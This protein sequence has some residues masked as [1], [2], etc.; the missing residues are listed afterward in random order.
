M[1]SEKKYIKMCSLYRLNCSRT[2]V[3]VWVVSFGREM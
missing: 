3:I 2:V 1:T